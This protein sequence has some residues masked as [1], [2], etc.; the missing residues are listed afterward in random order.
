[1]ILICSSGES[2]KMLDARVKVSATIEEAV[3]DW[4]NT[5][6]LPIDGKFDVY[7]IDEQ[8]SCTVQGRL[9]VTKS[10]QRPASVFLG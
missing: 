6:K 3:E 5:Y 10:D 1:M 8:P 2:P 4:L 7:E 9:S